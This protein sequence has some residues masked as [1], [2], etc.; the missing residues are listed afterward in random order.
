M[1]SY[2]PSFGPAVRRRTKI[3]CM[4]PCTLMDSASSYSAP[5]SMRVRGWYWPATMSSSRSDA[6]KP[7]LVRLESPLSAASMTFGPSNASS[8]RPRPFGF[9]VTMLVLSF[10]LHLNYSAVLPPK[11]R[12]K[13]FIGRGP[14]GVANGG[15]ADQ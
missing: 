15:Q 9:L 12:S 10:E 11:D 5:S 3:G 6:G 4:M 2:L 1:I 8:P 7:G 13:L 14:Y